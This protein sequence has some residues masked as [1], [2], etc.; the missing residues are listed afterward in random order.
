MSGPRSN[1][2][3]KNKLGEQGR[4]CRKEKALGG[5]RPAGCRKETNDLPQIP[6]GPYPVRSSMTMMDG[7]G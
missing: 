6:H 1:N 3:K 2:L 5:E 4:E 7:K